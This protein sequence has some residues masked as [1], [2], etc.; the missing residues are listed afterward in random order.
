M[1][2]SSRE[3]FLGKPTTDNEAVLFWLHGN[4]H[5]TPMTALRE[6]GVYRLAARI[7]DLRRSGHKITTVR[8]GRKTIYYL[9]FPTS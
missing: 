3:K 6:L 2:R 5:I 9:V 8:T 4:G 7:Y 1:S